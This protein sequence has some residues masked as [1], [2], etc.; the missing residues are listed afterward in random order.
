MVGSGT[1]SPAHAP[2]VRQS[3]CRQWTN[4]GGLG[5]C[6]EPTTPP[7]KSMRAARARAS[8]EHTFFRT[9]LLEESVAPASEISVATATSPHRTSSR[10][11]C[12]RS[13]LRRAQIT[14]VFSPGIRARGVDFSDGRNSTVM[15]R[16]RMRIHCTMYWSL[17]H[18]TAS[19]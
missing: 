7:S 11:A 14:A 6:A 16:R 2:M 15:A 3:H 10:L 4:F 13:A 17:A 1:A 19:V 9:S 12:A 5:L 18:L 8:L